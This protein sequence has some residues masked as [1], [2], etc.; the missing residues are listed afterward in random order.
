M[1]PQVLCTVKNYACE[2]VSPVDFKF[3]ICFHII[4][5][6]DAIDFWPSAKTKMAA[7]VI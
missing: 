7:I 1:I 2:T 6:T 3:D 4:Y 5:R